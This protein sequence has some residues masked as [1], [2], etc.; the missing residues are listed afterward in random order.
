MPPV[1]ILLLLGLGGWAWW[2]GRL[3]GVT[4]E[5]AIAAVLFLLGLRLLTT[6]RV[7]TGALLMGGAILWAAYR[8]RQLEG[9]AMAVPVARA[10]LGVGETATLAEVRA[11]YAERLAEAG[12]DD[13]QVARLDRARDTIVAE[14]NKRTPRAS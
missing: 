5:D 13:E 2:T 8:R 9:A 6:G 7:L 1:L 14:M 12:E 11:A 4:Y 3:K 10:I